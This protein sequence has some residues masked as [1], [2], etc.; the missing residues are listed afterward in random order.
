MHLSAQAAGREEAGTGHPERAKH[1]SYAHRPLLEGRRASLQA[2][3]NGLQ[4]HRRGRGATSHLLPTYGKYDGA[5]EFIKF[6]QHVFRARTL[7]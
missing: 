2:Y 1:A 7:S 3:I 6:F 4:V 5:Y